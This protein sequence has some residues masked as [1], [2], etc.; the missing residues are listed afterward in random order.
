MLTRSVGPERTWI[1]RKE[2]LAIWTSTILDRKQ[3]TIA[4]GTSCASSTG[5]LRLHLAASRAFTAT[6]TVRQDPAMTK[7][8][9][10]WTMLSMGPSMDMAALPTC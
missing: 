1:A 4:T 6:P 5:Q 10:I 9:Q 3:W 7:A 2:K 8:C